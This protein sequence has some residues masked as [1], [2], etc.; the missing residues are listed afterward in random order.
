MFSRVV[1]LWHLAWHPAHGHRAVE[2]VERAAA[3]AEP[4]AAQPAQVQWGV[5]VSAG[6]VHP[7]HTHRT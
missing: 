3:L 6:E 7:V 1:P 4:G 5:A 2:Q